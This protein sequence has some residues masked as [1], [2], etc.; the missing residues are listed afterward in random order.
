MTTTVLK[1]GYTIA[2]VDLPAK[3]HAPSLPK[4]GTMVPEVLAT[5]LWQIASHVPNSK[6]TWPE[7]GRVAVIPFHGHRGGIPEMAP[8][9]AA[10]VHLAE[11]FSSEALTQQS[12]LQIV[13]IKEALAR[14]HIDAVT[15]A[16]VLA[17][18]IQAIRAAT[19]EEC[20]RVAKSLACMFFL[21]AASH[22]TLV[23]PLTNDD[24][25]IEVSLQRDLVI[26]KCKVQPVTKDDVEIEVSL[27]RDLVTEK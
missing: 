6:D 26:E 7:P 24:A 5:M 13:D 11:A 18:S 10:L 15:W 27:Q 8:E 19:Y 14:G 4:L 9:P 2:E 16:K 17:W 22:L 23:Q 25:E 12:L 20:E 3:V 1:K 21:R